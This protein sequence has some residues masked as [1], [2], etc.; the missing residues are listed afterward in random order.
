MKGKNIEA[1]VLGL[2]DSNL[3]PEV[4]LSTY[5]IPFKQKQLTLHK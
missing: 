4:Y 3:K 1:F 5:P 2:N